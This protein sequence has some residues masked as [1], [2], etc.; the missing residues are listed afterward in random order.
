[1][2]IK[3]NVFIKGR[4]IGQVSESNEELA[5]C[6]ALYRFGIDGEDW[7]ESK[8]QR[9]NFGPNRIRPEEEFSVSKA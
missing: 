5:R 3:W 8:G 9:E 2:L 4:C 6:A 7:E 1:M